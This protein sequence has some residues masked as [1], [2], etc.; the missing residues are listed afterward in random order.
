MS[1]CITPRRHPVWWDACAFCPDGGNRNR[2]GEAEPTVIV[3]Y[4]Q[5]LRRVHLL[6]LAM[7]LATGDVWNEP[8]SW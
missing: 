8:R 4:G 5:R 2:L 3:L 6:C 7:A 1:A